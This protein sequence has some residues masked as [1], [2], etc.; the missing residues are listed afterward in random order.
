MIKTFR[1]LI[2]DGSTDRLRIQHV[3]GKTG[4]KIRKF[5]II[6]NNPTTGAPEGV[7]KVYSVKQ[8]VVDAVIDFTEGT[9]LAAAFLKH[10]STNTTYDS[11]II[12]F[13]STV[14]N[15][16]LHVTYIDASDNVSMNYYLELEQISLDEM[17]ATTVILKNFR[18]TNTVA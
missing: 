2:A 4:Y 8:T 13:D 15:Q 7:V 6:D 9:L 18:N 16:D 1:G 14:V 10:G 11:E 12:I 3:D 17:E 5:Q